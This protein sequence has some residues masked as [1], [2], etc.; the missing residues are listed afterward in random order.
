MTI[1]DV[2]DLSEASD[3]YDININTLKSIC[4][5]ES[6][7]LKK[8]IDYKKSGRVWLITKDAILKIKS[9]SEK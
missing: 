5:N 8:G 2:M 7:N 3:K 6:Y 1:D 9:Q 4:Q